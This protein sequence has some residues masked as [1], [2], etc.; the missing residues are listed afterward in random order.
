MVAEIDIDAMIAVMTEEMTEETEE[1]IVHECF[2]I[3]GIQ[4]LRSILE[5]S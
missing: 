5:P 4:S 1:G 2:S 3:S